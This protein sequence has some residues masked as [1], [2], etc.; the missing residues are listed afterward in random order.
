MFKSFYYCL[1]TIKPDLI[2]ENKIIV[3]NINIIN[4]YV[5][6]RYTLNP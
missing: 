5:Q 3:Y 6:I 2:P 4:G 1:S